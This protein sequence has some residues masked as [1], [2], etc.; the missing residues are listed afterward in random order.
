MAAC[1]NISASVTTKGDKYYVIVTYYADG[2]RKQKWEATGLSVSGNNKRKAETRRKEIMREYENRK[3]L[4]EEHLLFHE[5]LKQWLEKTKNSISSSTYYEYRKLVHNGICPYYEQ[6][7]IALLDLKP[8]HIQDFYDHKL[9]NDHVS[10]ATIHHYHASMHKALNY[11]VRMERIAANPAD[12]VTLP[13]KEKHIS[14]HYSAEELKQ[15]LEKA[16]GTQIEPVV[17]LAAWFGLRRGEIIGMRWSSIDFENNVLSVTGTV[18][19][20]GLSGSKIRNMY[21]ESSTKTAASLRSF[22]MS[23]EVATY[24]TGLKAQQAIQ[25]AKEGYNHTWDDFVCVRPNGDLIPPEYVTRAFPKLCEACGLRRLKL[26][27]LRHTN[28]SLLLAEGASMKELQEWAGHSS[29]ATTANTYSHIQAKSKNR[30][31][32]AIGSLLAE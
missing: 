27:E 10:A 18:K 11:A 5:F 14:N 29:Y 17:R 21:Y 13:K 22:P 20:K 28:I 7:G 30:L 24:L 19:D 23:E 16:K 26:H 6:K 1:N 12:K 9:Q 15:V 31:I 3:S 4:G 25:K 32:A 8:Y 2:K